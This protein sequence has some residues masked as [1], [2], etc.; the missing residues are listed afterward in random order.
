[1][2]E[3]ICRLKF[4]KNSRARIREKKK[5]KKNETKR[6]EAWTSLTW[7]PPNIWKQKLV[8]CGLFQNV[9]SFLKIVE[10]G[11]KKEEKN[12]ETNEY[13]NTHDPF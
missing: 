2:S 8:L 9:L 7:T 1:M 3:E 12:T 13:R 6:K 5:Q 4:S 11:N 10:T